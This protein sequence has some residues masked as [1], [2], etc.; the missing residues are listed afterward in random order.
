MGTIDE[1]IAAAGDG[2][3][4]ASRGLIDLSHNRVSSVL[5]AGDAFDIGGHPLDGELPP[6]AGDHVEELV[7]GDRPAVQGVSDRA[8]DFQCVRSCASTRLGGRSPLTGEVEIDEFWLGG[9][10]EGLKGSRQRGKKALVGTAIEVRGA[11]SG[12][13]R[14]QVLAN[15]RA[16]TLGA[17]TAPIEALGSCQAGLT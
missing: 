3:P 8:H 16:K 1:V 17:F 9:Y 13:L 4:K 6:A 10:E 7:A 12:R 14:L 2:E 11:G 5:G 15:S